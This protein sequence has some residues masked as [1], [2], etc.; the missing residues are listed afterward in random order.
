MKA[1]LALAALF[2]APGGV[3]L[4]SSPG[5]EVVV[6]YNRAVPESRE[7]AE[8]YA[9][10]RSVP[11]SQ[12]FG[13]E[14]TTNEIVSRAE[15]RDRLELPLAQVLE[16][17]NL[18]T[19]TTKS[20]G[21][22]HKIREVSESSVRYVVLCYG[23]PLRIENDPYS[24][25]TNVQIRAELRRDGASVET[26]L[27][28][29]PVLD[30]KLPRLGPLSNPLF[31]STNAASLHPTNGV[32]MV[33]RLDGPS[34]SIAGALVDKA[35]EAEQRGLWGRAYFD[36]R[37]ISDPAYQPGDKWIRA[38]SEIARRLGFEPVVDDTSSTFT[39]DFPM[40][41]IA[42]YAGWY[43]QDVSG[44]FIRSEVEFMPGAFA[45]H[46]HSFSAAT[47]R[48]AQKYWVGP[49]LAKGVTATMGCVDEPYLAGTP[50]IS[51]FAA[52]LLFQAFTF[53]EAAYAA[54]PVLSWQ[55]TF[56]GDPLYQPAGTNPDQLCRDL[57][58]RQ[59]PL[60]SW[61]YVRLVN[62]NLANGGSLTASVSFLESLEQNRNSAVLQERLAELYRAQ[63]KPASSALAFERALTLK[64]SPQQ[65]IRI[66]LTL[67]EDLPALGRESEAAAR[68][69]ELLDSCPEFTG[70]TG[71]YKRLVELSEKLGRKE[72]VAK[73]RAEL[74]ALSR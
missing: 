30:Q 53:G 9:K 65:R 27:A 54:Q 69:R 67:G 46:L 7:I 25:E 70:K 11:A 59:D 31:G 2:C 44:P 34:P 22:A 29:L 42:F 64:P 20:N 66:L 40:S 57:Q 51:V 52:R 56:V 14:L 49:L 35:L 58:S 33:T 74:N 28:L 21:S 23:I 32:L 39:S 37:N 15:Y 68:Y 18:W 41:H 45:Y 72:D 13:F 48:D 43:D 61:C 10:K 5:T 12:L 4:A 55:T 6:V 24:T 1:F 47:V 16:K 63:G 73:Y 26:E 8:A 38:A 17:N 71:I 60:L 50:E 19:L 62:M 36:L 3:A